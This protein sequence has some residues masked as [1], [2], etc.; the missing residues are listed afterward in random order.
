MSV[1]IWVH[2]LSDFAVGG[3]VLA[4]GAQCCGNVA[5][6]AR[7]AGC[8]GG[9]AR[10]EAVACCSEELRRLRP[11]CQRERPL[12]VAS[13]VVGVAAARGRDPGDGRRKERQDRGA[14]G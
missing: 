3:F 12:W 11:E 5:S 9:E 6:P 13:V 8:G 14:R 1:A 4:S 10:H 7:L 2:A